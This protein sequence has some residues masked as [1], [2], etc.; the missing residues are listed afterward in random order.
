MEF[1]DT[2]ET[3]ETER[4]IE[5]AQLHQI[6]DAVAGLVPEDNEN[7]KAFEEFRARLEELLFIFSGPRS[8]GD[9]YSSLNSQRLSQQIS[10]FS[11]SLD[12][13]PDKNERDRILHLIPDSLKT[14]G[15]SVFGEEEQIHEVLESC[16][17]QHEE[18]KGDMM[19]LSRFI[20]GLFRII[21]GHGLKSDR[22]AFIGQVKVLC[23]AYDLPLS[24]ENAVIAEC[25]EALYPYPPRPKEEPAPP[26][27]AE[28]SPPEQQLEELSGADE[29]GKGE[30]TTEF[31]IEQGVEYTIDEGNKCLG[32][33]EFD[34][35][36]GFFIAAIRIA[37]SNEKGYLGIVSAL[38]G[39]QKLDPSLDA[40]K[41]FFDIAESFKEIMEAKKAWLSEIIA[42]KGYEL[43]EADKEGEKLDE[44]LIFLKIAATIDPPPLESQ[45]LLS[46]L[47][48]FENLYI[49]PESTKKEMSSFLTTL[50]LS[51]E[52]FFTR[53][54]ESM[55]SDYT[56][57]AD[58]RQLGL[59]GKNL[60]PLSALTA[61][62]EEQPPAAG[63]SGPSIHTRVTRPMPACNARVRYEKACQ[64]MGQQP[65]VER[66]KEAWMVFV[67]SA[68]LAIAEGNAEMQGLIKIRVMAILNFLYPDPV[69]NKQARELALEVFQ[70]HT[71][72]NLGI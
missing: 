67:E 46:L 30:Y 15:H 7:Y 70:R 35:A 31:T 72:L 27:P 26:P 33:R 57:I 4:H 42:K 18:Y 23:E 24:I 16:A 62:S 59:T 60:P 1:K 45:L 37:P 14:Y 8:L 63:P 19:K 2:P 3:A 65:D 56:V 50:G 64:L 48:V 11:D 66:Y 54:E 58:A 68:Q 21:A 20:R 25:L 17:R 44:I 28:P 40:V 29:H 41:E 61:Q 9:R 6:E 69:G 49:T 53:L 36:I 32:R 10:F 47:A 55:D 22:E 71:G 12:N 52:E 51:A 43:D 38:A 39:K 5:D 13:L 34:K